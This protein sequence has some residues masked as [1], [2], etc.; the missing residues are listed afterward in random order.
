MGEGGLSFLRHLVPLWLRTLGNGAVADTTVRSWGIRGDRRRLGAPWDPWFVFIITIIPDRT[1]LVQL[2]R[3]LPSLH[4]VKETEQGSLSPFD[5]CGMAR[6]GCPFTVFRPVQTL[7]VCDGEARS[8]CK[9]PLMGRGT[10]GRSLCV[11]G[12]ALK[13][14]LYPWSRSEGDWQ[15]A[16]GGEGLEGPLR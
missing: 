3:T 1:R 15:E 5:R 9:A 12:S 6:D 13:L 10:Q 14:T 2:P 4:L 16:G 8:P 11:R 7:L